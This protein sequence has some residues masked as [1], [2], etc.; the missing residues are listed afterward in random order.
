[1]A[2]RCRAP[3]CKTTATYAA[4]AGP[5][6]GALW[7]AAHRAAGDV[8][9]RNRRCR[10]G[11]GAPGRC[12]KRPYYG[13]PGTHAPL[14][15]GPHRRPGD[16]DVVSRR[17][18]QPGCATIPSYGPVGARAPVWCEAHRAAASINVRNRGRARAD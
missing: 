4:D 2:R 14:Y 3:G 17:C 11:A 12:A 5:G 10:H 13:P 7:C 8:D 18:A 6:T 15:C 9:V 1:M 16:V